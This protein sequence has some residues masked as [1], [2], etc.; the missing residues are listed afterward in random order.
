[1]R[2]LIAPLLASLPT[3]CAGQT[4]APPPAS[5][6][7]PEKEVATTADQKQIAQLYAAIAPVLDTVF[8]GLGTSPDNMPNICLTDHSGSSLGE[9][10]GAAHTVV[11]HRDIPT[12]L[13]QGILLHELRHADQFRRGFC[14]SNDISMEA[15]ARAV[16]A[17]EADASAISL[18][19]AWEL[20]GKGNPQI[21]EALLSWPMQSDIAARFAQ[22][23]KASGNTTTA[24]TMAFAQWYDLELRWHSYYVASCSDFL[25]RQD[26]SHLLPSYNALPQSFLNDLCVMSDGTPYP[27]DDTNRRARS[28]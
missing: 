14:P 11:L 25:D 2:F 26:E 17:M 16:A 1:M 20:S 12:S 24:V 27:C 10:F 19:A 22:E 4:T 13:K 7:V 23:M 21:W 15:N 28:R 9:Y 3:L 8:R 18:L 5:C 6:L